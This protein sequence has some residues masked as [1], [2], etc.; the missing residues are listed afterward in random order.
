VMNP[1]LLDSC[2]GSE[3]SV[4]ICGVDTTCGAI[5]LP[6]GGGT[7]DL[8]SNCHEMMAVFTYPRCGRHGTSFVK[9]QCLEETCE[10][11]YCL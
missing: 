9:R 4:R 2:T 11:S 6:V 7:H 8:S 1:R 5:R 3:A 10:P